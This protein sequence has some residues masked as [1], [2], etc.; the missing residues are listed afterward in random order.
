MRRIADDGLV[1]VANLDLDPAFR[2]G[3][4]AEVADVT[5]SADPHRRPLR[6]L[7]TSAGLKPLV[8]LER[9]AAN[10]RVGGARH[11]RAPRLLEHTEAILGGRSGGVVLTHLLFVR[12]AASSLCRFVDLAELFQRCFGLVEKDA[13][14]GGLLSQALD[15]VGGSFGH[16]GLI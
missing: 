16:K 8:E 7:C 6:K 15:D 5:V 13:G 4:W 9:T 1:E 10:V 14:F 12:D 11:L 3:D 2:V